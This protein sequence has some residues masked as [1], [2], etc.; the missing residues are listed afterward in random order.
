MGIG[1]LT[2]VLVLGTF[3][4]SVQ[5]AGAQEASVPGQGTVEGS[6]R[7][8]TG[9]EPPRV[10]SAREFLARRGLT[11]NAGPPDGAA[12]QKRILRFAQDDKSYFTGSAVGG[13][14]WTALGPV[15]VNSLSYGL[16]T[17]RISAIALDPADGTGNHVFVGTTGGGLWQSQNAAASTPGSVAFLPLTDNLG[18]LSGALEAGVSVGAVTV[19]PGGTGVVLAGLGDPNDALDSYYGAGLLRSTD[20]GQTWVLIT[21]TMDREDG[22][23]GQ[24]YSFVGE[25][26]AGFAWSTGNP[27][28][29]VAA[30]SQAYEGTLVNAVQDSA[31]YEGLYWSADA[32]ATWHLA[33]ITDQ[34][35]GD[36]QGPLDAFVLP[37]GNAAT[38]VVWNPVRRVFVAAVRYHGYYE[39]TD[40]MNWTQMPFY[41]NGQPGSGFTAANCPT[42]AGS[43]GVAG[44]PIFRGSLAVNPVTGDTFAWS[45][46]EF[47][48]DQGIW[49]DQCG[50][51]GFGTGANCSN[52]TMTFGVQLGTTALET[53]DGNGPA[54]IENGDYNLT[55]AAIPTGTGG[56]GDTLLFAG[57]NDL[58]KCSL[59]NSCAWRNTT[60]STTCMSA[61]VGEY[62][63]G[64]AW[65]AGNP[66][67]LYA[68]TDSGLWR[69]TDDVGETGSVC[70]ATDS[71]HWQNLNGGLGSLAE[72]AS[73][74]QSASSAATVLAG[75][76]ANG[77][78]GI[79]G[80]PPTAGDWNEVLGGEGGPVAV[81]PTSAVNSWYANNAA[82]VSIAHCSSPTAG[83][84]CTAVEFGAAPAIGEAQVQEDGLSM[85]YPAEFQLDAMNASDVVIGT[86]RVWRGP[87][88]GIGWPGT[89]AISPILDGSG[90][91]VCNGNAL[92][93]SIA[94][95][96]ATQP[97]IGAGE[98]IYVGMAGSQ[99]GGGAVPGH[100]FS[101]IVSSNGSVGAWTDL[102]YSPVVNSG[103][104]F[105]TFGEDVSGIY[106]D[107]HDVTGETVY[108]TISGFSSASE[109]LQQLYRST[110]GG[111]HWT[112]V[113]W[114]LPNAP[115]NAVVVDPQD[116]NTVYVATDAGVYMTRA[117]GSCGASSAACWA[118]YGSGL[119]LAPV[120]TLAVTPVGATSQV[121]TAGTYGRGVW[122]VPTV[123]A[124]STVTTATAAPASLTFT[125]QTVGTVSATQTV[126]LTT[127]GTTA[128]SVASVATMGSAASD[129]TE[130]DNCV[131]KVIAK[132]A[133]CQIKV[134]FAPTATGSRAGE[135]AINANVASGQ[136]V[137][138][139]TGTGLAPG[140]ITLLPAS[141]GFGTQEVGTT[142]ATQAFSIQNVG[143]STVSISSI[144]VS[145]LF[146]KVT[147]T[148]GAT[149]AAAA[150]CA[151]TVDFTP[152]AAGP[153]SGTLTVT[154]G[155]GT[156]T[157]SLTGTGVLGPTDTLSTTSISFSST[158]LGATSAP[159]T[160]TILNS[161]GL[162]LTSIGTSV[163]S[164]AGSTD[165]KAVS[166]CGS[167][168]AAGSSCGVS[169]TF[170]PSVATG[171]TGTLVI[172]D[173]LR[174]QSVKLSGTGLKPP[175]ISLSASTINFGSE[176]I[177]VPS[178]AKTLTITNSGGAPLGQPSFSFSGTGGPNFQVGA[179]TC[180]ASV[181]KGSSCTVAVIFTPFTAGATT[182]T[183]TVATASPGVASVNVALSGT[184]L[185]PPALAVSPTAL[186]LGSVVVGRS[187]GAFTV[188]V[189][190]AGQETM[191]EPSFA[192]SGISG[193]AGA[194]T[195][196]FALT[197]PTD[198]TACT[199]SVAP[200]ASCNIQV[201]FSPSVVG[202]ESATLTVTGSNAIPPTA[203]V[204][205]TGTGSPAIQLEASVA[206]LSFPATVVG[207]TTAP[208]TFSI[209]NV[210]NQ[211]ANGLNFALSGPYSLSL[212]LTTCGN[213]LAGANSCTVG[214]AFSPTANG[215]QPGVLTATVS[216]AGVAPLTVGLD[217][218]GLAAGGIEANPTQMTFG[219]V[220][221]GKTSLVQSL[222]V[223]NSGDA[224]LDGLAIA[225]TGDFSLVADGC[226][227]TLAA[228]ASCTA[229][230]EFTPGATGVLSG[231]LT[232]SS[233]SSGVAPSVVPLTGNGILAGSMSVNP[234]VVNFGTVTDGLTGPAQT[235]TVTNG[236][237]TTLAGLTFQVAGDYNLP[238]NG[239]GS[240]LASGAKCTFTVEF[241]P[242]VPG[243]RIGSVTIQST[244]A[245]FIP[246]VVGL[247]GTGLPT[248]QLVVSPSAL[249]LGS[250]EVGSNSN[251]QQITVQNPGTGTL[252]GL[253]ISTESPFSVG[254][255]SCGTSLPPGGSCTAPVTFSPAV[256]GNQ[257]GTVVVSS[258][259]LGVPLVRIA[260][261]GTGLAP[262]ALSLTPTA[263]TFPGT[264]IGTPS[265]AQT[266]TIANP[267]GEPL[268]GLNFAV[269]GA[270]AGDFNASS[271]NCSATLAGGGSCT[272][273]VMFTP[274][275]VGGR[276]ALLTTATTTLGSSGSVISGTVSLNGTGLTPAALNITPGSLSFPA[277]TAGQVSPTQTAEV[278]NLGQAGISNLQL[279][280]TAGFGIDPT[281]TTC[282]K[283]LNG[284]ANCTVGVVFAPTTG[285][286][287][288]GGLTASS[289]VSGVSGVTGT[290]S[291]T[292]TLNG[293]GAIAPGIETAPTSTVQFGTTGVGQTGQQVP[294]T[295]TNVG[296][297]AAL[298]GLIPALDSTA[299]ANGFGLGSNS[300][301]DTLAPGASCT[302]NVTFM[303][304]SA[305]TL[306]GSLTLKSANGGSSVSLQLVGLGFDFRF[307]IVGNNS[308]T[309]VQGQTAY[310]TFAL[311]TIGGVTP[312]TG[313]K[314]TF[315][316][317]NL[318]ANALCLFNPA[319]LGVPLTNVTGNVQLGIDTGSAA[320]A[321]SG[322]RK[323]WR[324][325]VLMIGGLMALP[326]WL[327]R[328]RIPRRVLLLGLICSGV[329]GLICGC[330]GSSGS[331]A[332]VHLGGGTPSSSYTVM[333]SSSANGVVHS[334]PVTLIV[335]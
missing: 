26:F 39:S 90:G 47:N 198:I 18:A 322:K 31:S 194:Q 210:G 22:M 15:G 27:Q 230:V 290:I 211:T 265:T 133:N 234:S 209:S 70:A 277:T 72:V 46:D 50:L 242:T 170:S 256:S 157:A 154:D 111:A 259:S 305:G 147:N 2:G 141:A 239:C 333:V 227:G 53:S 207:T 180:G 175:A 231:T 140:S 297:A 102:T 271:S 124:G 5:D 191:V 249:S 159:T 328:R 310:Y 295:I 200:G 179:T 195:G 142:S 3:G 41:P 20:G 245:G 313:S 318:P 320:Q 6:S 95:G 122:Q 162:P 10:R 248:A 33:R 74:G 4:K 241:S 260:T 34:D 266:V 268:S 137:V 52:P 284:G 274:S 38:S 35:G 163:S 113:A 117:I 202:L 243:T 214:V 79:I 78:A 216:N 64:F 300:C 323:G 68:G 43:V 49:Q 106:V 254:S 89:N 252:Q 253:S 88:S 91:S 118:A 116:P 292:A 187:S 281:K 21:Q 329:T 55:L 136:L 105:N 286:A 321:S 262:A 319:Q 314:F 126:T 107:P 218:S 272:V 56:G 185:L 303:P 169:V 171:E 166:N 114:Y 188:Q 176:Q 69:S 275:A 58:W 302:I 101:A 186:N 11:P 326:L 60:N 221:V 32:G 165:F 152:T 334:L 19:Q 273:Q 156:Q 280:V 82:G 267:G 255:G 304:T 220:V 331:S 258:T 263:L 279:A 199:G 282:T 62:Q 155:V 206:L 311:T 193:P 150:A 233:V 240:S 289:A 23:G 330:A 296:T 112:A 36:V 59:A 285:G 87:A 100:L 37:D 83:A 30:V 145:A 288:T 45:V 203:T 291:A 181:A 40:G 222:T 205:F 96:H 173:A 115:A 160:V 196:D 138:P 29:V 7:L 109:P 148:C 149:L 77:S 103:Y 225:V 108:V 134:S 132:S 307:T 223:T 125:G 54:T 298:T 204:S 190:N 94:V 63:H 127:T 151:V 251:S 306:T 81:D 120:T 283:V 178:A 201:T 324:D 278:E 128:L 146:A 97:A 172:S 9:A 309:V 167:Q 312:G 28:L 24:D 229:D 16:V 269:S 164:S 98:V 228:G 104:A 301:G 327:R 287:A 182:A 212:P 246:V 1:V 184:G 189:K 197:E 51:V 135:L 219:S 153:A 250:V 213:K 144:A 247:T 67:L 92:I 44:C 238:E 276:Q 84:L 86:C 13:A 161:G 244:A 75:L 235:V 123:T 236:G 270:A 174:A 61:Q 130:T 93:R 66:L 143:G 183:L 48:Q 317:A 335:N 257:S 25:G 217:G 224:E 168:L 299:T 139:L 76:G 325:R 215:N 316:C 177:N 232:I 12:R 261:S 158:V 315:Q 73:L 129:F 14:V 110:D 308:A 57:D 42:E 121:L 294:V 17:G 71:E 99:D 85:P 80:A 237:A 264:G 65:D 131:G 332:E 192:V 119:P 226:A 8:Q 293:T 208:L